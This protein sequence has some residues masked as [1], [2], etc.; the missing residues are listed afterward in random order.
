MATTTTVYLL[1]SS[2]CHVTSRFNSSC[3][4]AS[5][6]YSPRLV[7]APNTSLMTAHTN[8]CLLYTFPGDIQWAV[9]YI[10]RSVV[11]YL[12]LYRNLCEQLM[13]QSLR[14]TVNRRD[15]RTPLSK[16]P[17]HRHDSNLTVLSSR[18][19][20]WLFCHACIMLLCVDSVVLFGVANYWL[21]SYRSRPENWNFQ[22]NVTWLVWQALRAQDTQTGTTVVQRYHGQ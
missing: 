11:N 5:L 9:D 18:T 21:P 16:R 10:W 20:T 8:Y 7:S 19:Q 6:F 22:L 15:S 17:V 13:V 1:H 12:L 14:F 2:Q 3:C 4:V